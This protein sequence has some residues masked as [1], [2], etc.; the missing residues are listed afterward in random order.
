MKKTLFRV[1]LVFTVVLMA[2]SAAAEQLNLSMLPH[3]SAETINKQLTPL[4]KYLT[5]H[6]GDPVNIVLTRDFAQ[7]EQKINADEIQIAFSSPYIY[8][9]VSD[10]HEVLVSTEPGKNGEKFQGVIITRADSDITSL[11][12][13]K[14]RKIA[15]V[16]K[17]SAIGY[18]SQKLDLQQ[19][20]IDVEKE[21]QLIEAVDNKQENV[22]MAVYLGEAAAGFVS[23]SSLAQVEK[24][25]PTEQIKIIYKSKTRNNWV[26]SIKRT[27]PDILKKSIRD[28]LLKL[29]DQDPVM[30]S[31]QIDSFQAQLAVKDQ[32]EENP[33]DKN[34]P[35]P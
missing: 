13:L 24:F 3:F 23:E 25:I 34:Q 21:C 31:L 19:S 16:S 11:E 12:G 14:N 28:S 22:I 35:K 33:N 2:G 15:I 5:Q 7:Y 17:N 9:F 30:K 1:L 6:I 8:A 20:G 32:K 18:L 10:D 26:L 4:A 29:T 27:L